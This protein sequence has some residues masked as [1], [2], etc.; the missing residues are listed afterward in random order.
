MCQLDQDSPFFKADLYK[1]YFTHDYNQSLTGGEKSWL[2]EHGDIRMGFLNNDPAIF[3]L[4]KE[5]EQLAGMLAE[6]I[7]YAKDCLGNQMLEFNIQDYADYDEM[8]QALQDQEIN[9]IFY[10]GRNPDL[11]EK[12]GYAL[13]NTAWTYSLMA[14]TDEKNFNED[15]AY[16]VAVPKEKDALKQH[17]AFSYPQWKL[18]DYDSL[19]DAADMI[20]NEKADC[21]LMGASQAMIYD[22]RQNFK[23]CSA[24]KNNGGML[25]G[26]SWRGHSFV[27]TE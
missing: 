26:K 6:Y 19:D 22:N 13:T 16:T 27:D 21:F 15:K 14:V 23:K 17:L 7:S 25:C 8:L 18:V 2:E 11:A 9:V 5:N 12:K 24:Y 3:S 1:K 10:A 4:D 20:R